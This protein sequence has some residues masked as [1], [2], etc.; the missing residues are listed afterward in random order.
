[1]KV[2][3][4]TAI[5]P[6]AARLSA[7]MSVPPPDPAIAIRAVIGGQIAAIGQ[8]RTG[9]AFET[10][11]PD[12]REQLGSAARFAELLRRGF[13]ILQD[14]ARLGFLAPRGGGA[15]IR[16]RVLL[17]D[18]AGDVHVLDYDMQAAAGTWAVAGMRTL[19]LTGLAGRVT[20]TDLP[21][22]SARP[23]RTRH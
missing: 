11:A 6:G 3:S 19:P 21:V 9:R 15:L 17:W 5:L 20:V 1:M 10:L 18:G 22:S 23:G 2:L 4:L 12:I 16:Q 7:V 13:P 14:A 8:G